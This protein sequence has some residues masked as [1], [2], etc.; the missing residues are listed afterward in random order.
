M[1]NVY[2]NPARNSFY[3]N[4]GVTTERSGRFDLM[5]MNGRVV[6]TEHIP[7]GYQIYQVDIQ[8]LDRGMYI[9]RW[10][11]SGRNLGFRKI[12]KTE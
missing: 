10:H 5:D 1:L 3:V 9:L 6:L 11:E 2:P 4:L 8:H 7:P 12:V